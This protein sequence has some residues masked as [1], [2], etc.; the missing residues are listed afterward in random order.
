MKGFKKKLMSLNYYFWNTKWQIQVT[1]CWQPQVKLG[2]MGLAWLS[3]AHQ[4]I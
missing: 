3:P 2:G 4:W 1:S